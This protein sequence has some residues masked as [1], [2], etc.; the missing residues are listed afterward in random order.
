[1]CG[2]NVAKIACACMYVYGNTGHIVCCIM[3]DRKWKLVVN[4]TCSPGEIN[5]FVTQV[6]G[7]TT[8]AKP[9]LVCPGKYSNT[10]QWHDI[11]AISPQITVIWTVSMACST[12]RLCKLQS[13][14]FLVLWKGVP[15]DSPNQWPVMRKTLTWCYNNV[16]NWFL[17]I[18]A[19]SLRQ[20][21]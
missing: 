4:R 18:G 8:V 15:V 19:L 12:E 3:Y 10:I 21:G 7:G 13:S 17:F 16:S 2:G 9:G 14:A 1:M 5:L 20:I 11:I 6:M